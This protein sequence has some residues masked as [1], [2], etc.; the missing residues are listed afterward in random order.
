VNHKGEEHEKQIV[1]DGVFKYNDRYLKVCI[2]QRSIVLT[3][4]K[5]IYVGLTF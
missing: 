4:Q 3:I 5:V 1:S 2:A